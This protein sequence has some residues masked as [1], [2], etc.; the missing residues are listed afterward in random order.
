M[1][2]IPVVD[3][4]ILC[5]GQAFFRTYKTC[6]ARCTRQRRLCGLT[7]PLI[8]HIHALPSSGSLIIY[9]TWRSLWS[10]EV[11]RCKEISNIFIDQS[12]HR[13][14]SLNSERDVRGVWGACL[15]FDFEKCYLYIYSVFML[16]HSY[17]L[18][19]GI[20]ILLNLGLISYLIVNENT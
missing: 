8:T 3:M 6:H 5:L 9:C 17:L 15:S 20:W 11:W 16:M 10:A 13:H 12:L 2:K 7:C 4:T 19:D 14:V 1:Q 18:L